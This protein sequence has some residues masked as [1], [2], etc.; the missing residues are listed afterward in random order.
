MQ[1]CFST[2]TNDSCFAV[3]A[4]LFIESTLLRV[5]GLLSKGILRR[6]GQLKLLVDGLVNDFAFEEKN[7]CGSIVCFFPNCRIR[8]R[9]IKQPWLWP[10]KKT[11][12]L[13]AS[14]LRSLWLIN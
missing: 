2:N 6:L 3:G 5:S 9:Q 14:V 1:S 13:C 10:V 8:S 7:R 11:C 4:F 12:L